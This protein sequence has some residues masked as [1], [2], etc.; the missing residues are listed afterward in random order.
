MSNASPCVPWHLSVT[1]WSA[2]QCAVFSQLSQVHCTIHQICFR[3]SCCVDHSSM[4]CMMIITHSCRYQS[5]G[6]SSCP[7]AVHDALSATARHGP[8]G[9]PQGATGPQHVMH[10]CSFTTA[11]ALIR[12][13]MGQL[14]YDH[15]YASCCYV[16]RAEAQA[17][18]LQKHQSS[19]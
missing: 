16:I 13:E 18:A 9:P 6:G 10:S 1:P 5:H 12:A 2:P 4:R 8:H 19:P 14:V 11:R 7:Q 15:V 3:S 17:L